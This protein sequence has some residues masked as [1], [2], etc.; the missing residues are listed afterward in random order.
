MVK[1]QDRPAETFTRQGGRRIELFAPFRLAGRLIA[2]ID[3][4]PLRL[5]HVLRW[6]DG[7]YPNAVALMAEL[8]GM[9]VEAIRQVCYPDTDRVMAAFLEMLPP[10]VRE[11]VTSGVVPIVPQAAPPAPAPAPEV[12]PTA[13]FVPGFEAEPAPEPEPPAGP[14]GL[15]TPDP[16]Y[17]GPPLAA[18]FPYGPKLAV[19]KAAAPAPEPG[20]TLVSSDELRDEEVLDLG[21]SDG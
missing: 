20:E 15:P 19:V 4:Q 12:E 21:M 7:E 18:M 1:R 10:H 14:A 9:K 8:A 5:D 6:Q 16:D 17:V 3:L 2:C 11:D 13:A